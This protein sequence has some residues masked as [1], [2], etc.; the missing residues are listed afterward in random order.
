M[1]L[2]CPQNVYVEIK[3]PDHD[4]T[5]NFRAKLSQEWMRD[6]PKNLRHKSQGLRTESQ[7]LPIL[8]GEE[9]LPLKETKK[10]QQKGPKE[11]MVSLNPEKSV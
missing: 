8:Y 5:L 2:G 11:S 6:F 10:E 1:L 7:S 4:V 3:Y 9:N